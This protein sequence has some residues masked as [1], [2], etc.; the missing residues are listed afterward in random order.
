MNLNFQKY[1]LIMRL[2]LRGSFYPKF[3]LEIHFKCKYWI[4]NTPQ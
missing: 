1:E 3:Q 2:F 4:L